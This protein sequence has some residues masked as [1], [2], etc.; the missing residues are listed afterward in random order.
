MKQ[1]T[2]HL[3]LI[4]TLIFS[5]RLSAKVP[6]NFSDFIDT[7]SNNWE[8]PYEK[9]APWKQY[10]N[11]SSKDERI[12]GQTIAKQ[13]SMID[14]HYI[15]YSTSEND[16][17]P[18]IIKPVIYKSLNILKNHYRHLIRKKTITQ[19][20]AEQEFQIY[21]IKGYVCYSEETEEIEEILRYAQS[22]EEIKNVFD[23][24]KLVKPINLKHEN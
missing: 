7:L 5:V 20:K 24:I 12:F 11:Y 3:F 6:Y 17:H 15:V 9:E 10:N 23:Q 4:I 18:R 8:F 21:L 13:L 16:Y 22:V 19:N 1:K 14:H 2:K